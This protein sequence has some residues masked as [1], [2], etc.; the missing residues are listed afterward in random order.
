[1]KTYSLEKA[2]ECD[3]VEEGVLDLSLLRS[4]KRKEF[5]SYYSVRWTVVACLIVKTF[6]SIGNME[7]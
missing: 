3:E 7:Y 4:L 1:M 2:A 6:N 5:I